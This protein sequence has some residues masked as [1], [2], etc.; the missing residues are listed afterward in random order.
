MSSIEFN[1]VQLSSI[2]IQLGSISSI[3]F[4]CLFSLLILIH[5][6][7]R[8]QTVMNVGGLPPL[9]DIPL[10]RPILRNIN[11]NNNNNNDSSDDLGIQSA[12]KNAPQFPFADI[13]GGW[14]SENNIVDAA[15]NTSTFLPSLSQ[16]SSTNPSISESPNENRQKSSKKTTVDKGYLIEYVFLCLYIIN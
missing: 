8:M 7:K 4:N 5:I 3:E 10:P 2:E 6:E 11:N 13:T 9:P 12:L 16:P 14:R 15:R 1:W